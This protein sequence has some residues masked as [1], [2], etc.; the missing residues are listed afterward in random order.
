MALQ[1]PH[2][3]SSQRSADATRFVADRIRARRAPHCHPMFQGVVNAAVQ[4]SA[5]WRPFLRI[6]DVGAHLGDCC[7]WAAARWGL[8][9]VR[10][11][12]VERDPSAAAAI[13]RSIALGGV[14]AALEAREVSVCSEVAEECTGSEPSLE[15]LLAPLGF[16]DVLKIHVGGRA[17]LAIL[18]SLLATLRAR[19]VGLVFLRTATFPVEDVEAFVAL[20]TLPYSL[21][22][23][24]L[25]QD[26]ILRLRD[27]DGVW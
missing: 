18:R 2:V 10:C 25:G 12:S 26:T 21:Q 15:C 6:V 11:L 23:L 17:E 24:R 8:G 13:R 16:V 22:S 20:H 3:R 19:K 1:P 14:A 27:D 9:A 4:G 7:L 5:Q